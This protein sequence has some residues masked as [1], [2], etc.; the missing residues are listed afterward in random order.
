MESV[1]NQV[2]V[3]DEAADHE[4]LRDCVVKILDVL[5]VTCKE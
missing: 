3:E 1:E 5:G 4:T 2:L